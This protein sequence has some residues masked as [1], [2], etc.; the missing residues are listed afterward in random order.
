MKWI[1]RLLALFVIL[2]AVEL[3]L[4]LQFHRWTGFWPT[5]ALILFTGLFGGYLARR[6][7]LN[8]W[9][10]VQQRLSNAQVPGAELV[11]G[12]IVLVSGALL[13]TPGLLSD[14]A[15]FV[16]LLP[17][18]RALIRGVLIRRFQHSQRTAVFTSG[19]GP[20][21]ATPDTG[22]QGTPQSVPRHAQDGSE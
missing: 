7:G 22:W 21:A 12:L 19:M 9:R 17:P 6:E 3:V 5:V 15:G 18:T 10:R 2:P 11:D 4:L 8:A 20:F 13:V 1:P 14:I 16:G